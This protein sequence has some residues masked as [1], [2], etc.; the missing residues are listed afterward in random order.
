MFHCLIMSPVAR[1]HPGMVPSRLQFKIIATDY[2]I[3]DMYACCFV[4]Y[5]V[6]SW[7]LAKFSSSMMRR[8]RPSWMAL[9]L[10]VH[11]FIELHQPLCYDKAVIHEGDERG[12]EVIIFLNESKKG[13]KKGKSFY[14]SCN[15]V[16]F[17]PLSLLG[18]NRLPFRSSKISHKME[19]IR[20][21][22]IEVD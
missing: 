4:V 18:H 20:A 10:Q 7:T 22:W 3:A 13:L 11:T 1:I 14:F 6:S 9:H 19:W 12:R 8:T 2:Y 15:H 17:P 21:S 16:L 5:S